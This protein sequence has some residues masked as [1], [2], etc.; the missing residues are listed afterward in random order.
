[1]LGNSGCSGYAE[2]DP[3]DLSSPEAR[4]SA[5]LLFT[6]Y[7]KLEFWSLHVSGGLGGAK[8]SLKTGPYLCPEV[9][10]SDSER[11]A[12]HAVRTVRSPRISLT[13][14]LTRQPVSVSRM[15]P[16]MLGSQVGARGRCD[17]PTA[18]RRSF[19]VVAVP[20]LSVEPQI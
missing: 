16:K 17:S 5:N 4:E 14:Q 1:M 10:L 3:R 18:S 15:R 19:V 11:V 12:V 9:S 8:S 2:Q 20:L 6:V 7:A 13:C